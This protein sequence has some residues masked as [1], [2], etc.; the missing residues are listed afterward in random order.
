MNRL[1]R[2]ALDNGVGLELDMK[3]GSIKEKMGIVEPS[4]VAG[5]QHCKFYWEVSEKVNQT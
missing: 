4:A 5:A 1:V 3:I 2:C